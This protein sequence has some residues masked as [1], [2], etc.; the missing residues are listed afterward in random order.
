MEVLGYFYRGLRPP[1]T[2]FPVAAAAPSTLK[3][4]S[5]VYGVFWLTVQ[6]ICPETKR[7]KQWLS[8]HGHRLLSD[9]TSAG[10]D[11]LNPPF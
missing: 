10:P 5:G 8:A 4:G 9:F 2:K 3:P 6:R 1:A 7:A 11:G